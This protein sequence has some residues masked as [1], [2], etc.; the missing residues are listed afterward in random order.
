M[1]LMVHYALIFIR[2]GPAEIREAL[3]ERPGKEASV[4]DGKA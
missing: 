4:S 1:V 3:A 2:E